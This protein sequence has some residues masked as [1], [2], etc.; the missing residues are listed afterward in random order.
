MSALIFF[1]PSL[2]GQSGRHG[3]RCGTADNPA[4]TGSGPW[5]T[6]GVRDLWQ[7]L[8]GPERYTRSKQLATLD[9][10]EEKTS[11]PPC[12]SMFRLSNIRSNSISSYLWCCAQL[13]T[14]WVSQV[15]VVW[16]KSSDFHTPAH[17]NRW[18][19]AWLFRWTLWSW[20]YF[21]KQWLL[22]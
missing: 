18:K 12:L 19:W 20:F 8:G 22:A 10:W 2:Q 6:P 7:H 16:E 21:V 11:L 14:H 15:E 3:T 13:W 17:L 1:V 4:W 9:G 5:R